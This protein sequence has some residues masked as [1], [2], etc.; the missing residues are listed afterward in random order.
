MLSRT[1][2]ASQAA[3]S[4]EPAQ[5]PR[6]PTRGLVRRSAAKLLIG[7]A[8]PLLLADKPAIPALTKLADVRR[9]SRQEANLHYPVHIRGVVTYFDSHPNLFVQDSTSGM[10]VDMRQ[11]GAALK[12]GMLLDLQA[13]T[14][15]TDFAVDLMNPR[16]QVLGE[17][18]IPHPEHP[19]F[20]EMLSARFDSQWVEIEGAIHSIATERDG[21]R[22]L[23]G[24]GVP[25]GKVLVWTPDLRRPSVDL[26]GARVRIR[27][28]CGA[29]TN[30]RGQLIGVNIMMP[31]WQEV[32]VLEPAP[33][34]P[35]A[36]PPVPIGNLQQF[37]FGRVFGRMV[38]VQGAVT[39][40]FPGVL[41]MSDA[42]GNLS[43]ETEK[44]GALRPG[45]VIDVAGFIALTSTR[46]SL[47]DAIYRRIRR[48]PQPAALSVTASEA[49]TGRYDSSLVS[50][51]GNVGTISRLANQTILLMDQSG[52]VFNVLI[53]HE[54]QAALNALR[55]RSHARVTGICSVD[56]DQSRDTPVAFSIRIRS[57]KD[58]VI[59]RAAPWLTVE[60]VLS[61]VGLLILAITSALAW[62]AILRGR[63]RKQTEIIRKT[64]ESAS[65]GLVVVDSANTAITWNHKFVS[66]WGIPQQVLDTRNRAAM[67]RFVSS[68]V[69]DSE[70]YLARG[71]ALDEMPEATSD[72][73]IEFKDGR[74]FERH[75][76]P[77]CVSGRIAGRVWCFRDVT[78]VRRRE[79]ELPGP[80]CGR[81]RQSRKER[82]P[83]QYEPRDSH[84]HERHSGND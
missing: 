44:T 63:V 23:I 65:E 47:Q 13:N 9:L 32:K 59:T 71:R 80:G 42:S 72:D 21:N 64:L 11:Q 1:A 68:Q 16:W 6:P 45:D 57:P 2:I 43:V 41:Y 20:E 10:W 14:A 49:L 53:D 25:G 66:M 35:F 56:W 67:M 75:S 22:L 27:G 61:L 52:T 19:G 73:L 24:V 4:S 18:P 74:A 55:E 34:D 31:S 15:Q 36:T 48:E 29:R 83:R 26:I 8:V 3:A 33:S 82:V 78:N 5:N 69:A 76:E 46:P 51:E 77:L 58:I 7:L 54:H 17:A 38:H 39:A 37:G 30:A 40:A 28:V 62:I 70:G 50:I 84:A 81:G 60:R 79:V 12:A